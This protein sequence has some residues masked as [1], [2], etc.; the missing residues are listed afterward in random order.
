MIEWV[1]EWVKKYVF[2]IGWKFLCVIQQPLIKISGWWELHFSLCLKYQIFAVGNKCKWLSSLQNISLIRYSGL[3]CSP[4]GIEINSFSHHDLFTNTVSF[5]LHLYTSRGFS[6]NLAFESILL[7]HVLS[8][9][10][11]LLTQILSS[12][13]K[14]IGS[15]VTDVSLLV[16]LAISIF[17]LTF[18]KLLSWVSLHFSKKLEWECYRI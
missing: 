14:S 7:E 15:A 17:F 11:S 5:A 13:L 18:I 3:T 6:Q 1:S 8:S 12:V 4:G 9:L 16:I 2:W 10:M